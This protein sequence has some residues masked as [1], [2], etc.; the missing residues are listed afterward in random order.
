MSGLSWC[1]ALANWRTH[2][3]SG[4]KNNVLC[5]SP[6]FQESSARVVLQTQKVCD[7]LPACSSS[8]MP[9][10]SR[11]VQVKKERSALVQGEKPKTKTVHSQLTAPHRPQRL[12]PTATAPVSPYSPSRKAAGS[13]FSN[14][15]DNSSLMSTIVAS[16]SLGSGHHHRV[17]DSPS[18]SSRTPRLTRA[19][20]GNPVLEG[21]AQRLEAVKRRRFME[22]QQMLAFQLR[23]LA[24]QVMQAVCS[25]QPSR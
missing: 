20:S 10:L 1:I 8:M 24:R 19:G 5:Q 18:R 7:I 23:S 22:L 15:E 12:R 2:A 17:D 16:S 21:E 25:A 14:G 9:L 13:S 4:Q 3:K 11:V 6:W